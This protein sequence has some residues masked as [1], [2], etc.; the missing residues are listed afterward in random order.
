M[1]VQVEDMSG[2]GLD[3]SGLARRR[4]ASRDGRASRDRRA[5]RDSFDNRRAELL[6]A[7]ET[8]QHMV[9][10]SGHTWLKRCKAT[11]L[12]IQNSCQ[13]SVVSDACPRG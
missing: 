2:G 1:R 4:R 10:V 3:P 13:A 6:D 5:S 9:H 12:R 8:P 11:K 7:N